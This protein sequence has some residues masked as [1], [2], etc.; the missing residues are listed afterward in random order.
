MDDLI[1]I[2]NNLTIFNEFKE[3]MPCEIEMINISFM[4]YYLAIEVKQTK[5][6]ILFLK[7]VIPKKFSRSLKWM[8][9]LVNIPIECGVKLSRYEEEK[10][11]LTQYKSLVWNLC[12]LTCTR[13]DILFGV[14]LISSF[15]GS[16]NNDS[17]EDWQTNFLLHQRYIWLWFI[18]FTF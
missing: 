18:F 11:T 8:C 3:V 14:G 5:N 2:V 12:S 15:Y 1:F 4:S 9:N 17:H 16:I 10:E 7:K 13:L 6:D